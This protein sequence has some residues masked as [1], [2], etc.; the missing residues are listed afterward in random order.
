LATDLCL[1]ITSYQELPEGLEGTPYLRSTCRQAYPA[2]AVY[3]GLTA[4]AVIGLI[5]RKWLWLA[6]LGVALLT[7]WSALWL[8]SSGAGLLPANGIL[9]VLLAV[10]TRTWPKPSR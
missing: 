10:V 1:P 9:I 4:L 6:W 7:M 3:L 2:A 5:K 8:F